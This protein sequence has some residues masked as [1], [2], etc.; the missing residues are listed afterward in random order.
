MEVPQSDVIN[1]LEDQLE[2]MQY[3]NFKNS[4]E[5]HDYHTA[6]SKVWSVMYRY[7]QDMT[8]LQEQ[9][10]MTQV[11][12]KYDPLTQYLDSPAERARQRRIASSPFP[13]DFGGCSDNYRK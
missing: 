1:A 8:A 10:R 13:D 9:P 4:I 6:C 12:T 7:Q 3:D 2:T 5:D 11:A